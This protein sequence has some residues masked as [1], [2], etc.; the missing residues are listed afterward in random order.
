MGVMLAAFCPNFE[1]GP[2]V[3]RL[4]KWEVFDVGQ[5]EA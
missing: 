4:L 1:P 3:L 2:R 5:L